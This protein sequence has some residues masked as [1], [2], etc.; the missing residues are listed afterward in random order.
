[1]IL[2]NQ[3]AYP[4]VK[5]EVNNM[6]YTEE[7]AKNAHEF[8]KK[9]A[10]PRLVGS[11][12]EKKAQEIIN[13]ELK[14]IGNSFYT[15]EL[16]CSQFVINIVFRF[17]MPIGGLLLLIAWLF[18]D[19]LLSLNNPIISL[20]FSLF[21]IIWLALS[22]TIINKS[23]GRVPNIGEIYTTKNYISEI[24]PPEPKGHL[25]YLAH[26]DSKSQLYPGIVRVILFIVG[27]ISGLLY[28]I[29]VFIRS[30][31]ILTGNPP[32][33]FWTP[34]LYSALIVFI[35]NFALAFNYVGN[36][37]P[38]ALDDATGVATILELSKIFKSS[39]PQ[40]LQLTFLVTAAE[41]IGLYGAA[42]YVKRRKNQLNPETT[43]F[44]NYDGIGGKGKIIL[45]TSY[46]IPPKKTSQTLN[47]FIEE[48]TDEHALKNK[49]RKFYLPIGVASD[50][51]PI[52]GAGFDVTLLG[53]FASRFHTSKD[54]ADFIDDKALKISGV[55]G[56][57]LALKLDQKLSSK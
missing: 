26:Y 22:S 55:I 34:E 16:K 56:V 27:L 29:R 32:A 40:N 7:N 4:L 6:P 17:I 12:G 11:V 23:F 21:G 54:T 43:F 42:D 31:I 19:P 30:I 5:D 8:A 13:D 37:S 38:G 50:H 14:L 2:R 53:S 45:L 10:F 18:S 24:I 44:L 39:P 20:L 51:V 57:E 33:S 28:G 3:R 25:I 52:Q 48:I 9:I 47:D 1:M 41:E 49:I 46:G 35:S 36:R 15:E